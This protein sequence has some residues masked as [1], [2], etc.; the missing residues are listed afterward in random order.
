VTAR[1]FLPY[2]CRFRASVRRLPDAPTLR[3][4]VTGDFDGAGVCHA[5]ADGRDSVIV[6]QWSVVARRRMV[7]AL[8]RILRPLVVAN[9]RFVLARALR[10]LSR[11]VAWRRGETVRHPAL[12]AIA[13]DSH[14]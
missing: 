5:R 12:I 1:G 10:C 9:H 7:R 4:E 2:V 13:S 6:V 3:V 14:F 11:E 8:M